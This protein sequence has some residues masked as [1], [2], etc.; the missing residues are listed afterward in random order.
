MP[1]QPDLRTRDANRSREA[2]LDAAERLFARDGFDATTV[3]DVARD[4]GLSRE[5][6]RYFFGS[7]EAL[8]EAVL[9]RVFEAAGGRLVASYRAAVKAGGGREEVV[10]RTIGAYFDFLVEHP[11]FVRLVE[12]EAL[13][14]GRFLGENAAHTATVTSALAE[15]DDSFAP[16]SEQDAAQMLVS[17]VGLCWAVFTHGRLLLPALGLDPEDPDFLTARKDHVAELLLCGILGGGTP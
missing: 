5:T 16:R 15:I 3:L 13:T 11:N 9:E 4:A 14:G 17:V 1:T 2:I 8:Y 10:K 7:K 12:W 6:P